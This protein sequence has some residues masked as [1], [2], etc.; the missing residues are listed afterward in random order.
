M[1]LVKYKHYL[2]PVILGVLGLLL[3]ARVFISSTLILIPEDIDVVVLVSLLGVA[4]VVAIHTIVRI[5]VRYLRLLSVK[6]ARQETLTEHSYFLRRLDHE[7]KNPLTTLRAGLST[8]SLTNL[9]TQQQ[10]L[11]AAMQTETLRLSRL[12]TDLRKLADL[13]MQP[14]N[15]QP[16]DIEAFVSSIIQIERDRFETG[17]RQLTSHIDSTQPIWMADE[18]LLAL[19]IHNLLDNAFKY[20]QTGDVI[21]LE[22][23]AQHDLTIRISDSGIGIPPD[24]LP[25]IWNELYRV[26]RTQKISGS[27][28][29]LALVKAIVER[30]NG[31]VDVESEPGQGT[32]ASIRL[33][34]ASQS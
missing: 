32:S 22:I 2:L 28:I 20:T 12:V 7:L 21:H 19:A 26:E 34:P 4:M 11:V 14:L 30:H 5:S 6:R 3:L 31:T 29:G 17:G 27:G 33:P 10:H 8:L 13:E 18:D 23:S 24:A 25:Y 15:L 16:I 1:I 9:D